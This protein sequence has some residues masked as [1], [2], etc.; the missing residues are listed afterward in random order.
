MDLVWR[1]LCIICTLA[2]S[3]THSF[4]QKFGFAS[5]YGD[6]MVLQ[7]EP[8]R[9][10]IWGY[11][12]NEA[13]VTLTLLGHVINVSQI[14]QVVDGKWKAVLPP[15]KPG[16]P[17]TLVAQQESTNGN[18]TVRKIN[19]ILF[20]DVWL[21][22][23]QSNMEMTLSQVI[24]SSEELSQAEK[25]H[26]VRVFSAALEQ[27]EAELYD[28]PRVLLPWSVPSAE[29]LGA[30]NFTYF[31]AVCWLFGRY[32]YA[33]L[34]YPIG[35]VESCWGGTIIEVWSSPRAL[36][37][38][39]PARSL[40]RLPKVEAA[41]LQPSVLWNAM[42]HPLL[43]MTIKG[44]IWYQGE[45]NTDYHR[46]FYNCTFPA[47]IDDWRFSF[48]QGSM[49]QTAEDFPFGFVQISTSERLSKSEDYPILR[50]HQTADMG[51][52]PNARM[53]NTFMAVSLDLVDDTSPWGSIH[54][55]Y[56]QDVAF[57]LTLGARAVVY[58]EKVSFQGPFP[59]KI[60]YTEKVVNVTFS[61]EILYKGFSDNL[62]Q[63]CCTD[64]ETDC[65]SKNAAWETA[66]VVDHSS[67]S[68]HL[69]APCSNDIGLRYAWF[70][71]PCSFKQC[72]I[73]SADDILPA[74][75]FIFNPVRKYQK[76]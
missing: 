71:W 27:S 60:N 28:L 68:V 64:K 16:G 53:K 9:A 72:S 65:S 62:F 21:C 38:C 30:G 19:D 8:A 29:V 46:D 24:N 59:S 25:F 3:I 73:Y 51:F 1:C 45:S 52:V 50:W 44:V 66:Q 55:R 58:G 35:L 14:A 22:G 54:P 23:G 12:S 74:P 34:K 56:K 33:K 40:S 75:P 7:R 43:N 67:N 37:K 32:L 42:I 57:R 48:H 70:N 5:Y 49:K 4:E 39:I 10:V 6:H 69:L 47:M 26:D 61:Q 41:P 63:F 13:N 18:V 36:K 31:S 15:M 20:G 2:F 11:G 76:W 17:F